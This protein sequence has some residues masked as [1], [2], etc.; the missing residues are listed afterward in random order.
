MSVKFQNEALDSGIR[1]NDKTLWKEEMLKGGL[2]EKG[3]LSFLYC[4]P[5]IY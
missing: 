5:H 4:P 1:R 3:R 2:K